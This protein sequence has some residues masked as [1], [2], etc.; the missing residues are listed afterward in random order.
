MTLWTIQKPEAATRLLEQGH[1][2]AR[3]AQ[4]EPSWLPAYRWMSC[5]MERR[6]G[7]PPRPGLLPVWSW[8]QWSGKKR[9]KPDL[10]TA[11]HLQHGET[12]LRIEFTV[13]PSRV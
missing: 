12:G 6:T 5:E 1:L 13:D 9:R 2:L 10:R 8:Y 4:V 7:P 11:G 3:P